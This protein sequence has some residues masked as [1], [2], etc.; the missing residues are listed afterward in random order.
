MSSNIKIAENKEEHAKKLFLE[1][2]LHPDNEKNLLVS[3]YRKMAEYKEE[4]AKKLFLGC[5]PGPLDPDG[6]PWWCC[7]TTN[8][9]F[10]GSLRDCNSICPP[11]PPPP[12]ICLPPTPEVGTS[13]LIESVEPNLTGPDQLKTNLQPAR[14]IVPVHVAELAWRAQAQPVPPSKLTTRARTGWFMG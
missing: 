9:C 4:Y 6:H 2:D 14:S 12:G 8:C 13:K 5:Y 1:D 11:Q 7:P 10:T 3:S